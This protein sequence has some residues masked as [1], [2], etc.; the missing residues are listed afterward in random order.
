M[1]KTNWKPEENATYKGTAYC[2]KCAILFTF[3]RV[4]AI[5]AEN[6][7]DLKYCWEMLTNIPLDEKGIQ[8][9]AILSQKA[10]QEITE[11]E[12]PDG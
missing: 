12:K 9:V 3:N 5:V 6:E 11:L 8:D 2:G 7:D 10:K 1:R 4:V